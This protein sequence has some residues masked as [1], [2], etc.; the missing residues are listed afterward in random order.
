MHRV[1]DLAEVSAAK[2]KEFNKWYE[3]REQRMAERK[4]DEEF[5][6]TRREQRDAEMGVRSSSRYVFLDASEKSGSYS[7]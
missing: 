1:K 6:R 3:K 5:I 7:P 2:S 4:K